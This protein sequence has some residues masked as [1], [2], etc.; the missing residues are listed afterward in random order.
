MPLPKFDLYEPKTL[1]EA[2]S[3]KASMGERGSIIAGGT[4]VLPLIRNGVMRPEAL[5]SLE[6]VDTL[7]QFSFN[8]GIHL[9]SGVTLYQLERD[10][11]LRK[12]APALCEAIDVLASAQIRSVATLGGNLCNAAPS[13]D[14]APPLMVMEAILK[15][16]G[17]QGERE[18]PVERFFLGPGRNA[19][20][21][22]E[23]LTEIF[24][25]EPVS[26][27]TSSFVKKARISMDIAQVNVAAL[28]VMDGKKCLKC[29]IVAGAVAPAPLRLKIVEA[30]IEGEEIHKALIKRVEKEA[31]RT[32]EPVSDIRCTAE[33]RRHISG[34]LTCRV[35]GQAVKGNR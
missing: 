24:I 25:P 20:E 33:Y 32:V 31:R 5:I 34:V 23:V 21:T 2:V 1:E 17:P 27:M 3:L 22:D 15:A 4:D 18:I 7:H 10:P 8:D 28:L 6:R 14:C 19:L 26:G 11:S 13:A 30:M 35:I 9:S 29:R 12:K 16:V